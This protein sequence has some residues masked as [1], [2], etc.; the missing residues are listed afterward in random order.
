MALF[1][2]KEEINQS[3][4]TQMTR[5]ANSLE[6]QEPPQKEYS[7]VEKKR[8]AYAL[9]LCLVSIS[10]IIDYSDQYILEQE[11]NGIL[12]NLNLE[13]MPKDKALL[14]VF[15]QILD[16]ITFFRIQEG[17]K[18][19]IEQEYQDR[20][21]T[22][23]WKAVPNCSVIFSCSN[24]QA[25]LFSLVTQV[26]SGYMNYR[27]EKANA[28]RDKE[29]AAWELHKAA[30]EQFNGLRRELFTTAWKLADEYGFLDKMRLTENQISQ[31]NR[32]LQECNLYRR[33]ALLEDVQDSFKAF[34]P[35][36]YAK[37]NT[38][39]QLLKDNP[40]DEMM[41]NNALEAY[42]EYF[43]IN[44]EENT[45]LRTDTIYAACA[46]EFAALMDVSQK[47]DKLDYINRA[48]Q[49]AGTHFDILQLCATALLD[50]GET[51]RASKILKFLVC[52]A[53]NEAD[54]AQL[55]SLIY[56]NGYLKN[57]NGS[58]KKAYEQLQKISPNTRLVEWPN[59]NTLEE[60][61]ESF[62]AANRD[63]IL[64]KYA[65]FYSSYYSQKAKQ[66]QTQILLGREDKEASFVMFVRQLEK[67][68]STFPGAIIENNGFIA[69]LEKQQKDI[70]KVIKDSKK[71]DNQIFDN[72]FRDAFLKSADHIALLPLDTMEN[73]TTFTKE[74]SVA[75]NRYAIDNKQNNGDESQDENTLIS[76][77]G[78]TVAASEDFEK[79]KT[80]ISGKKLLKDKAKHT[81]FLLAGSLEY[82]RYVH[83][84]H[85][86][87]RKPIA[88]IN[89]TTI[90]DCD[91]LITETGVCVHRGQ[92][93]ASKS[94]RRYLAASF[95][96]SVGSIVPFIVNEGINLLYEACNEGVPYSHIRYS[97]N[98][99]IK[100]KY[101]NKYVEMDALCDLIDRCKAELKTG[102]AY[103]ISEHILAPKQ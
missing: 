71:T 65:S 78:R 62:I 28:N 91:L 98:K 76:L 38:A 89:D 54:N 80:L 87:Q 29:K 4:L 19:F 102:V 14:D 90:E 10:Q 79:I 92:S 75:I 61:Y 56:I 11:Y 86:E 25:M 73:I 60:T 88:I 51:E 8:A 41:R 72:I 82:Q 69:L 13:H 20:M 23:I 66:F 6:L 12:N 36:W 101:S 39:L 59:G 34:P 84:H 96:S 24:P 74:Y 100:P 45:L 57:G 99:L 70:E 44:R 68:I 1:R 17:E 55:L 63:A 27:N 30:I 9:N 37:G 2:K 40:D 46:L 77:F 93:K 32:I 43:K 83:D 7:E 31:Y 97:G 35:F 50:L 52:E 26:G 103:Q 67:E 58:Y 18:R 95:G 85:L 5:I 16:T 64:S 47:E 94:V 81:H 15:R 21:K 33:L 3:L 48:I 49:H 42:S 53:Y 22:A